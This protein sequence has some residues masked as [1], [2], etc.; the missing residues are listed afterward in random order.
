MFFDQKTTVHVLS[1][2]GVM[3]TLG[4]L[5]RYRTSLPSG[6]AIWPFG[7]GKSSGGTNIQQPARPPHHSD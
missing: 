5:W 6:D 3:I 4:L 7:G 2:A 1:G